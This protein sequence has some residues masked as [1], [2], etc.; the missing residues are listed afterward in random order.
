MARQVSMKLGLNGAFATRRWEKP[1]NIV[2]LVREVGFPSLEFCADIIDPFFMGDAQF[3]QEMAVECRAAGVKHGVEIWD[4]YTGV[5]THRF[6]GFSHTDAAPRRRMMEWMLR[7]MELSVLLGGPRLGGH[8]D[9][10]SVEVMADPSAYNR[11]CAHAY[12]A[13]RRLA[14]LGGD[15]GM[16]ALYVEQMYIPSEI[17]WTLDQSEVALLAINSEREGVPVYLTVDVGHQAGQAYGMAGDDLDYLAWVR[18]FGAFCEVIHLQ[19]TSPE[20]SH[21]WPFTEEYNA[22]GHIDMDKFMAALREA[23]ESAADSILAECLPPVTEQRLVLEAIPGSTKSEDTLL[24]ELKL[25]SE[26]LY[27]YLPLEGLVWDV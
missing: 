8:M 24:E 7:A 9:A 10:I 23:H 3:V 14:E 22:K 6:H 25:S 16:K 19:Q 12:A 5:A 11:A 20:G 4:L 13:W 18:R 21:H 15:L 26:Y 2:G 1:D 27:Q 17:P